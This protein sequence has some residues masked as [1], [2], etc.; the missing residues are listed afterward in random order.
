MQVT[1]YLLP[2]ANFKGTEQ[3][4]R[5]HVGIDQDDKMALFIIEWSKTIQHCHKELWVPVMPSTDKS[6]C[7]IS[8]L[9]RYFALVSAKPS[10]PC[11][12]YRNHR[13]QL[14]ALMYEQLGSQLK[15]WVKE[16]GEDQN[17]YSLHGLRRGRTSHAFDM[18]IK[19]EYIKMMGDWAST[20]FYRYLDITLDQRL[21]ATVKFVK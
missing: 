21:K 18:G 12:C 3:L 17:K 8:N 9:L 14:K 2:T 1:W 13:C 19:P 20:C 5:W 7:R 4:T 15:D 6:V 16:L 10:D 11:F